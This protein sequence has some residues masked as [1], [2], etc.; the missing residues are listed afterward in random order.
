MGV[1]PDH[2]V[3]ATSRGMVRGGWGPARAS[4]MLISCVLLAAQACTAT[5]PSLPAPSGPGIVPRHWDQVCQPRGSLPA[6]VRITE[7]FDTA[8]LGLELQDEGLRV[9]TRVGRTPRLDFIS[10]YDADGRLVE[11][12]TWASTVDDGLT[13]GLTR[14]LRR[15]ARSTLGLLEPED[16]RARLTLT[17]WPVLSLAP[18]IECMPHMVHGEGEPPLGLPDSVTTWAGGA[19]VAAD[20][21]VTVTV[22]ILIDEGGSVVEVR[23]ELGSQDAFD[24][25]RDVVNRLRFDPPLQNGRPV[26]AWLRQSFRFRRSSSGPALMPAGSAPTMVLGCPSIPWIRRGRSWREESSSRPRRWVRPG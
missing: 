23:R 3:R 18:T 26:R 16:F 7:L 2:G 20:D 6:A 14:V 19:R 9:P 13:Q 17:P 8:G 10:R 11:A 21:H 4:G 15:R 24:A 22:N 5:P 12:G 1:C 25:A